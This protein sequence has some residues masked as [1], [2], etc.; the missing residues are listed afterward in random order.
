[1]RP[2]AHTPR[3]AAPR[4]LLLLLA[5]TLGAAAVA[6]AETVW[7]DGYELRAEL[8]PVKVVLGE[9]V[10]PLLELSNRSDTDLE[11]LLSGE[12]GKGW[13]DGFEVR[14]EGPDGAPPAPIPAG[15]EPEGSSTVILQAGRTLS[16]IMRL[17][18]WASFTR[19]GR[20]TVTCRRGLRAAPYNGR[21]TVLMDV[22][23]PAVEFRVRAPVE[24]VTGGEGGLEQ[25]I[26]QLGAQML[27][28]PP[29]AVG[30]AIRL[31]RVEDA[32]VVKHFL[33]AYRVTRDAGV[34]SLALLQVFAKYDSDLALE[35]LKLGAAET[36]DDLRTTAAA[37]LARSKHPGASRVLAGM[38]RDP[39]FGVRL[40]VLYHLSSLDSPA[41]RRMVWEMTGDE[42]ETV[43]SE[44]LRI[45]G[46]PAARPRR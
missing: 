8:K 27:G 35:G 1:M 14:V 34:K 39:H 7:V 15:R 40:V 17:D 21:E 19:P 20:Y 10:E 5:L 22:E 28:P 44:A 24:V 36:N 33:A 41:A 3:A 26:E 45:A 43:R 2:A 32:R 16:L 18:R 23:K 13:P 6:R 29:D 31:S 46:A 38:R 4:P 11:L 42:H 12:G 30:A 25:L 37:A 9:P